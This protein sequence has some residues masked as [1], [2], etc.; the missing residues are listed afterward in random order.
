MKGL[1]GVTAYLPEK[2]IVRTDIG[3]EGDRIAVLGVCDEIEP[4]L[5]TDGLVLP[6]F[7]DQHIHGAG[8]ADV[9]DGTQDALQT[10]SEC[11]A[12]EGTT[13]FL[14]TTMTQSRTSIIKALNSVREIRAHGVYKGAQVLGAHLEGPFISPAYAGAQPI[15]YAAEPTIEAF[16]AYNAA[17]GGSIRIVTLAPEVAG[18]TGLIRHLC[19]NGVVASI[20]HTGA[21][22]ATVEQAVAAGAT[23]LTHTYNAQTPLHHREVGVV[24]GGLL[25][26]ALCC[27]LIC[28]TIHVSVPAIRLL[29]KSKPHDRLTL[30]TDAM[31]AK[32]MPDG[33]FE[34]GG[35]TVFVK[36]GE[37]R[38][39][40]GTLAGSVLRMN[41]AIRNLVREAGVSLTDAV[42]LATVSPAKTLGVFGE[43]GSIEIGKRADLTVLDKDYEVLYTIVGGRVVYR[44]G[45]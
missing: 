39:A 16:E 33:C 37:A 44:A 7:I 2:G 23:G 8:G 10:I 19:Q 22:F 20:G 5:K 35:Q 26:D 40:D 18:A 11:L 12:G 3:F 30:I 31:R 29:V 13:A 32:G 14:A 4:I 28:D 25:L 27:E 9:M 36:S 21:T 24:G 38:L 6:G 41:H 34:L 45:R 43:R 17:A 15:A 1:K 42:D